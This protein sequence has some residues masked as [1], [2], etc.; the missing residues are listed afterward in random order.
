LTFHWLLSL[1]AIVIQTDRLILRAWQEQDL[2][3]YAAM[4]ADARVRG[5]FP[6]LLTAAESDAEARRIQQRYTQEGF[7]L[8]AAEL[9]VEQ[10]F[11]GF[12][13]MQT[14]SFAVPGLSQPAVEIGWRL[15]ATFWGRGLASE[16][17]SAV[18][19]HAFEVAGLDRVVAITVPANLRSLRV[20]EK[21]GMRHCPE[22]EFAHPSLAEGSPL[23]QHVLYM[24]RAQA[25]GRHRLK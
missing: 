12:V 8:F 7:C 14:M 15:G 5:F 22:L 13:G 6:D 24:A 16:G 23:R 4:N 18:L 10:V 1:V 25:R 2:A 19:E 3:P 21:I 9:R 20:M 11:A 17:A